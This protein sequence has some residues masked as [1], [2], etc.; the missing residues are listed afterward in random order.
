MP[1]SANTMRP[2]ALGSATQVTT[3]SD[4]SASSRGVLAGRAPLA[5]SG[6]QRS[7]V[8]F[9]TLS[10]KPLVRKW[11]AIRLPMSPMPAKPPRVVCMG[12]TLSQAGPLLHRDHHLERAQRIGEARDLHVDQA[13][14]RAGPAGVV[15]AE[16]LLALRPD[17]PDRAAGLDGAAE[18]LQLCDVPGGRHLDEDEI[19]VFGCAA[20][21]HVMCA[22]AK[23]LLELLVVDAEERDPHPR[24][25]AE[26]VEEASRVADLLRPLLRVGAEVEGRL[27]AREADP[28]GSAPHL[29]RLHVAEGDPQPELPP[30]EERLLLEARA[31]ARCPPAQ[32]D[33][34][35]GL[36]AHAPLSLPRP[37]TVAPLMILLGSP[38]DAQDLA[39]PDPSAAVGDIERAVGADGNRRRRVEHDAGVDPLAVRAA[40]VERVRRGRGDVPEDA[41]TGIGGRG[42]RVDLEDVEASMAVEG[43]VDDPVEAGAEHL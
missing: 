25:H 2:T 37:E 10:G 43:D 6:W 40:P 18:R 31:A 8:R 27:A 38:L 7:G 14:V 9:Q 3:T 33:V 1:S 30:E 26:L 41:G 4:S 21:G 20:F 13:R 17:D 28:H 19:G 34:A 32:A 11:R 22:G 39:H 16:G 36:E 42:P 29:Q 23:L 5:T 12:P 24:L 15:L 35:L